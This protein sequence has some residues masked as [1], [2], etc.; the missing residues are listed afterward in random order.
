MACTKLT[1]PGRICRFDRSRR[2]LA[3]KCFDE[4]AAV[5]CEIKTVTHGNEFDALFVDLVH[6]LLSMNKVYAIQC[7]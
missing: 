3:K 4:A 6:P 7:S 1:L 2:G 5:S